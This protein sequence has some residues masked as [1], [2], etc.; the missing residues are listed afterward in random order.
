[1]K[2]GGKEIQEESMEYVRKHGSLKTGGS[3]SY[4]CRKAEG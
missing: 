2:K 4:F 1:V 3:C